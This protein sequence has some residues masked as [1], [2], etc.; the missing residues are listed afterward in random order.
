MSGG[1]GYLSN[2]RVTRTARSQRLEVS[3]DTRKGS[4]RVEEALQCRPGRWWVGLGVM[5]VGSVGHRSERDW[6]CTVPGSISG[7][8]GC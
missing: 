7:S 2:V 4:G 3:W 1:W 8:L 6:E 5:E